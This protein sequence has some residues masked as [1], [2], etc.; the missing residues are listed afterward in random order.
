MQPQSF[1]NDTLKVREFRNFWFIY[2]TALPYESLPSSNKLAIAHYKATVDVSIK[3]NQS[4]SIK[5]EIQFV[6]T[7]LTT[8]LLENRSSDFYLI[9][10]SH[11]TMKIKK[12]KIITFI[13]FLF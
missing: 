7:N 13:T 5:R 4:V 3:L 11:Q 6:D 1:G 8:S 2:Q 10:L 9:G 12:L